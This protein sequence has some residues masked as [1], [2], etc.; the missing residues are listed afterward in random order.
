MSDR[1]TD[2]RSGGQSGAARSGDPEGPAEEP[3]ED[4]P[5]SEGE[6]RFSLREI[7]EREAA[8]AEAEA[9]A[10]RPEPIEPGSPSTE[11][12]AFVLLGV[13]LALFVLSRLL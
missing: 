2:G 3:T 8:A 1:E 5:P 9:E 13:L 12:A 4:E 10:D 11:N 7:D 6:W